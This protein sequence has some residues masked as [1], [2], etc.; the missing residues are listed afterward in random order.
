MTYEELKARAKEVKAILAKEFGFY[1]VSV[2]YSR[3]FCYIMVRIIGDYDIQQ[4]I[5][6][7]DRVDLLLPLNMKEI[8]IRS[9]LIG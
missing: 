9:V 4:W 8:S 3:R 5:E 6:V 1:R 2:T 7:R